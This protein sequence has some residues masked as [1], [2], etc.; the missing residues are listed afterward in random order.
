MIQSE[1]IAKSARRNRRER[2]SNQATSTLANLSQHP[3]S[4]FK[5]ARRLRRERYA[6]QPSPCLTAVQVTHSIV[7]V[8]GTSS[9]S[10]AL[11]AR[12]ARR[13]YY[14]TQTTSTT[15]PALVVTKPVEETAIKQ[16]EPVK[17]TPVT[18]PVTIE[19]PAPAPVVSKPV[20]KV[21]PVLERPRN[22]PDYQ[23]VQKWEWI[24]FIL[25]LG[26][27]AIVFY[28]LGLHHLLN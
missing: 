15:K 28:T 27:G 12:R 20:P 23:Q 10:M 21:T 11:S 16:A 9:P 26:V 14:A 17:T 7:A 22:E 8:V 6:M 5:S 19:K 1:G 2:Y 18:P 24:L 13:A 3:I 4:V 25:L